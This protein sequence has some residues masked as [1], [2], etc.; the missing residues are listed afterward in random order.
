MI[1]EE[2]VDSPSWLE[3]FPEARTRL[4]AVQAMDSNRS[5]RRQVCHCADDIISVATCLAGHNLG[6]DL[7]TFVYHKKRKQLKRWESIL[8]FG[9]Y[10]QMVGII[11]NVYRN[12]CNRVCL[13]IVWKPVSSTDHLRKI[14]DWLKERTP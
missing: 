4:L 7:V 1:K 8:G 3:S 13:K 11:R 2:K 14:P 6:R 5:L 10:N 12:A 9:E